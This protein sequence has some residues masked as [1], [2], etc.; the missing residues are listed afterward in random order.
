MDREEL[1]EDIGRYE[2]I[3]ALVT[4]E[5]MVAAVKATLAEARD[6]LTKIDATERR[7]RHSRRAG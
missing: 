4:D 1:E 3:L 2:A 7:Q 6:Q 5:A